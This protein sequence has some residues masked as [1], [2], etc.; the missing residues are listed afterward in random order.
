MLNN[1][2]IHGICVSKVTANRLE[3]EGLIPGKVRNIFFS[4]S[5]CHWGPPNLLAKLF[6]W[7]NVARV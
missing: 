6:P 5:Y 2:C 1:L 7:T 4:T 3:N